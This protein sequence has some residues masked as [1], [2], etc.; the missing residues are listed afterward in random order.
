MS[1]V[2]SL[3]KF[4]DI[5]EGD[6]FEAYVVEEYQRIT[7]ELVTQQAVCTAGNFC[8]GSLWA[9]KEVNRD[10]RIQSGQNQ[11]RMSRES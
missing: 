6:I 3:E 9:S 11:S 7:I 8:I 5:K 4:N 2:S 10:G 1:A